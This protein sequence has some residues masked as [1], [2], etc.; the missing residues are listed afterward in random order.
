M[1]KRRLAAILFSDIAN[2]ST[3]L[4]QDER[5]AI[6][7]RK[8]N[9]KIHQ[10]L[11]RKHRGRRLKEMGDGILASFNSIIDAVLCS[12][13]IQK[14]AIE[15][16]I[17]TRI[18]IHLGEVIFEKKDVLG[19]GVNIGSR[20]RDI[21]DSNEIV[22]SETVYND[23]KNKEGLDIEFFGEKPLKGVKKSLGIYKITCQDDSLLDYTLDTGELVK[24]ITFGRSTRSYY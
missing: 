8:K 22:V 18:G 1:Q 21:A 16:D 5:K 2:Y 15:L 6:E 7:Q 4:G 20:V 14:A 19:D 3:L 17:P 13:S 10:K 23:I 12:L 11:I 24:P 9:F